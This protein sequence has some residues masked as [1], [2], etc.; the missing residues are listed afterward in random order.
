MSHPAGPWPDS[1]HE[2]WRSGHNVSFRGHDWL[3]LEEK[4]SDFN[5]SSTN[6]SAEPRLLVLGI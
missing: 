2:V 4:I 3:V 1:E 6:A 5:K